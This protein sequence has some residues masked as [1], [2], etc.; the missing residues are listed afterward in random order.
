MAAK[1]IHLPASWQ[2]SFS[3]SLT[4]K[5]F[6]SEVKTERMPWYIEN[7]EIEGETRNRTRKRPD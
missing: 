1:L 7:M 6:D 4:L 3:P 5:R 2:G